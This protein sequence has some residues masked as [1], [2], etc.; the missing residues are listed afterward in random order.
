MGRHGSTHN[1]SIPG[2]TIPELSCPIPHAQYTLDCPSGTDSLNTNLYFTTQYLCLTTLSPMDYPYIPYSS[3]WP[4]QVPSS[5]FL[6]LIL[7]SRSSNSSWPFICTRD[8]ARSESTFRQ[9]PGGW[10]EG[11][12]SPRLA[13]VCGSK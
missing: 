3:L 4:L 10:G 2:T 12:S 8:E 9:P 1:C 13:Q 7:S 11:R 5:Y 6:S